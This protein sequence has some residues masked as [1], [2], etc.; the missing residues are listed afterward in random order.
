MSV[1]RVPVDAPPCRK[2][3]R[4]RPTGWSVVVLC[5][6]F[7]P[8]AATSGDWTLKDSVTASATAVD[9][10]G[11]NA[12]SGLVLQLSPSIRLSG[13]GARATADLSYGLTASAGT[14]DTDPLG[15]SHNLLARGQVEAIEDFFF[16]GADASARLIGN[17][18]TAGR[19]D[20]INANADGRQSY[21]LRLTPQFRHRLNRYADIVSNNAVDY[22][23]YSGDNA[24]GNDGSSSHTLNLGVRSGSF[25]LPF[26]WA[27]DATRK[28]TDYEDYDE[29]RTSYT[30]AGG[31]RLNPRWRLNGR[32]GYEDND[33]RTTR[34]DTSGSIWALGADWT[35]NP[36][37]SLSAEYGRR[38]L[39]SIYSARLSHRTKRTLLSMDLSRDISNRRS[40][41][42]V[43]SFFILTDANGNI[44]IDP[45]TNL[46]IIVNI[47]DVEQ[48]DED[49]I[50]TQL[51]AALRVTGRRT[52]ATLTGT[53]SNREYELSSTDEDTFGLSLGLSRQL[54]ADVNATLGTS[55]THAERSG[56]SDS[57]V[58]DVR[59]S[60]G[61]RLSPRTRASIDLLHSERSSS[62]ADDYTENRIGISL[63]TSFL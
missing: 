12:S 44:L 62:T 17:S 34:A 45:S 51:R 33:V 59:L 39:G 53:V 61:R 24:S 22:V 37:T 13:R 49:F 52:T 48:I 3:R 57:D 9:R 7:A 4:P 19:V 6:A 14:G 36:R 32:V 38:Y 2:T 8:A 46:P 25:F 60:L 50:S 29:T 56:G 58:Y 47:P 27:L 42:L 16:L 35:P 30:A 21:S 26:D 28:E 10:S 54:G 43:D 63:S 31:Y 5:A 1:S 23:T 41:Q 15:L 40:L 55:Y 20:A 11:S 18:A